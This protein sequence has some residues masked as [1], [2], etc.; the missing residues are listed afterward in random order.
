M[1][2]GRT[3]FITL[4]L[5]LVSLLLFLTGVIVP[6]QVSFESRPYAR[7]VLLRGHLDRWTAAE[8]GLEESK[9][10]LVKAHYREFL[11]RNRAEGESESSDDDSDEE[12][13]DSENTGW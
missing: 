1:E 5:G 2:K 3:F 10:E 6:S 12:D 8:L 4:A 9:F 11:R 13:D 7:A